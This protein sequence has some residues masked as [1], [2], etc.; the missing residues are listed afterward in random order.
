MENIAIEA[1]KDGDETGINNLFNTVFDQNRDLREWEWK[2][3][4]SPISS[5][6]FIILAKDGEKI[7]GQYSCISFYLKYRDKVV[8]VVQPVDNMVDKDY[9]GGAKGIQVQTLLKAEEAVRNNGIDIGLGFPNREA[10]IVGKRLLKYNDLIKIE[11][12]F[13]RLSWRLAM[14]S[15]VNIPLLSDF[16]GWM[17]RFAIRFSIAVKE[18][19]IRGI[20]YRWIRVFDER[21][22]LFWEKLSEQYSIMVKRDFRYLNWR[23]CKKPGNDYHILQA[24]KD[25]NIIGIII[26]KYLDRGDA[27]IGF[28]MECIAIKEPYL[29]EN[30]VRRGLIFLS[31]NK[32]D[33]VLVRLSSSDSIKNI[34]NKIGFS[35]REGIWDSNFVFKIYSSNVESSILQDPSLWH[36]SFGDCDSL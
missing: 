28:I 35:H 16:A 8:R 27:R 19:P 9:R 10:Y 23:Y 13:K 25:G 12:F 17:S 32:V 31:Q 33:Y 5:R 3:M 20:Q 30:M 26:V 2:F 18:K 29:M 24:E 11:H 15:R 6:P 7:V 1:Y 4:E 34:F 36:I 14:K 21:I 22:D